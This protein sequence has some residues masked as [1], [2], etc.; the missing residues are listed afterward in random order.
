M[1]F[2]PRSVVADP[3]A[4][5][6]HAREF[7]SAAYVARYACVVESRTSAGREMSNGQWQR[8]IKFPRGVEHD[9][10]AVVRAAHHAE[11]GGFTRR[12][13]AFHR[14]NCSSGC[15]LSEIGDGKLPR[16]GSYNCGCVG[17]LCGTRSGSHHRP[18]RQHGENDRRKQ[19]ACRVVSERFGYG[20]RH[21][22][23][24][25][26]DGTVPSEGSEF[27]GESEREYLFHLE[28]VPVGLVL[29]ARRGCVVARMTVDLSG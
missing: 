17:R 23:R 22:H 1:E 26:S 10:E 21:K 11:N 29:D 2:E 25:L 27:I 13:Y 18:S 24:I 8:N 7:A 6:C 5:R 3:E 12:P 9:V 16:G 19:S 15:A 4:H 20:L 28:F 14:R